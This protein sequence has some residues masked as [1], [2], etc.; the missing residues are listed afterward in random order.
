M[1]G[2]A[3]KLHPIM[4]IIAFL[5]GTSMAWLY[6]DGSLINSLIAGTLIGGIFLVAGGILDPLIRFSEI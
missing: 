2:L 5:L 1:S 4:A 3:S 6:T